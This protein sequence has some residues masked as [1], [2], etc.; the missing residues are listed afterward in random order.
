MAPYKKQH[1]GLFESQVIQYIMH[2]DIDT[3]GN[4]SIYEHVL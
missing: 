2:D 1:L 3:H 4:K